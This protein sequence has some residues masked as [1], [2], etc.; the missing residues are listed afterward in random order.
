MAIDALPLP[1][2]TVAVVAPRP[3]GVGCAPCVRLEQSQQPP[4]QTPPVE[5]IPPIE[6]E[7]TVVADPTFVQRLQELTQL[8]SQRRAAAGFSRTHPSVILEL[9]TLVEPNPTKPGG[10][11][12][13][14]RGLNVRVN[15]QSSL[16]MVE[17]CIEHC[18][19]NEM[20][21][22]S[23]K[24]KM[25]SYTAPEQVVVARMIAKRADLVR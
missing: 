7:V 19:S 6:F 22:L 20:G 25:V 3:S 24:R 1:P 18:G 15:A 14:L 21:D 2:V 16:V 13:E 10:G 8:L 9:I 17:Y 12:N 4:A 5:P 11:A 23:R